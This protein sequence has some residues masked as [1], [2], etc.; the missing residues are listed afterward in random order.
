MTPTADRRLGRTFGQLGLALLNATL[1]LV[2]LCLFLT[3]RI[4]S[5]AEGFSANVAQT[6]I[7]MSPIRDDLQ[8][9]TSEVVALRADLA[10]LRDAPGAAV[11]PELTARVERLDARIEEMGGRVEQMDAR[12]VELRDGA[13]EIFESAI[14]QVGGGAQAVVETILRCEP[15]P[16]PQA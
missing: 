6:V 8:E 10:A 4:L 13:D 12:L 5:T 15:A 2:A 9:M 1:I 16:D 14:S 3:W 11:A 7:E